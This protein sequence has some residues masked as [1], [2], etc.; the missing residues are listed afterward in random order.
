MRDSSPWV[1][2]YTL[3]LF[4]VYGQKHIGLW[5]LLNGGIGL[6]QLGLDCQPGV[7]RVEG[8]FIQFLVNSSMF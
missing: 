7:Q 3:L 1:F 5:Q 8:A 4:Q 6:A 2:F